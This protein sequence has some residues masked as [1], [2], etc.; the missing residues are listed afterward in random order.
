MTTIK[1]NDI[2]Y[3]LTCVSPGIKFFRVVSVPNNSHVVVKEIGS[4]ISRRNPSDNTD[5]RKCA[6][7]REDEVTGEPIDKRII[8]NGCIRIARN[9]KAFKWDNK[10]V[11]IY[12]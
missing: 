8:S 9:C 5:W 6:M 7:P 1:V 2:F 3:M 12:R 4:A 10:P 11:N